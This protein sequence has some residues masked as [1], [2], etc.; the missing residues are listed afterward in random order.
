[1]EAYTR[2]LAVALGPPKHPGQCSPAP[3]DSVSH[4][5][6]RPEESGG[7]DEA[8]VLRAAGSQVF[9]DPG[10]RGLRYLVPASPTAR[11]IT[12]HVLTVAGGLSM[13]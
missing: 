11:F 10:G 12:T 13:S 5:E 4:V 1:M 8:F 3:V 7:G 9:R 2:A 6:Q